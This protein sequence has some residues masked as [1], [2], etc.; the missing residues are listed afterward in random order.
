MKSRDNFYLELRTHYLTVPY[1][2]EKR[3][4][5]VLLPKHYKINTSVNYPVVYFHDGQNV[6]H[7]HESFSGHS[8]KTIP[9][10]KRNPTLPQMIL[11]GIDNDGMNRMN[12]YTPWEMSG[13]PPSE[14]VYKGGKGYEYA[15]F[16][17]DKVKPFIDQTYRTKSEEKYTAMIGSSLGANISVFMGLEYKNKIGRLG[18][19]SLAN[20]MNASSFAS[21]IKDKKMNPHQLIYIQVGTEEGS[22]PDQDIKKTMHQ[23][24]IDGTLNY[25]RQLVQKGLPIENIKLNIGAGETHTEQVWAQRLPECLKFLS[26]NW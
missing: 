21:Y 20:W 16:V 9:A 1:L 23:T 3:R 2:D 7:S 6:F 11:V 4:I 14:E 25:T 18:I 10:L 12:E 17:M 15:K 26:Q 22:H 24:Y 8:W 5:R 19:F 13:A